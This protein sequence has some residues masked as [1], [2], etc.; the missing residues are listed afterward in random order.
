MSLQHGLLLILSIAL[1]ASLGLLKADPLK[2]LTAE[3]LHKLKRMGSPEISPDGKYIVYSVRKWNPDGKVNT[4]L[5]YINLQTNKTFPLTDPE[6]RFADS[7]PAFSVNFPNTLLFLSSRSGSNQ[8]HLLDFP[9]AAEGQL[10]TPTQFTSLSVDVNNIRWKA[11]TITFSA[12]VF[13][14]C[15]DLKCTADKNAEVAARGQ[16]TRQ[17]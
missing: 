8:I 4:Y 2:P 5:E 12:E 16:K 9:P 11:N 7:N 10:P 1:L 17:V 14:V 6:A 13:S 15:S 3:D